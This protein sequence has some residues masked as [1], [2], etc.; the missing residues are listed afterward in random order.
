MRFERSLDRLESQIN[1]LPLVSTPGPI[2]IQGN[3]NN[4]AFIAPVTFSGAAYGLAAG[5]YQINFTAPP[6]TAPFL[7][8]LLGSSI[9]GGF[10]AFVSQ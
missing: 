3:I 7:E 2:Q 8:V 5:I 6:Q 4:L 9:I 10:N 1:G